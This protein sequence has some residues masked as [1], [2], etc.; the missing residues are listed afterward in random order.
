M[1]HIGSLNWFCLE[2]SFA[3]PFLLTVQ[4]EEKLEGGV[5]KKNIVR[6]VFS[7]F[8]T[9]IFL[10]VCIYYQGMPVFVNLLMKGVAFNLMLSVV[11][12]KI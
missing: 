2:T 7:R 11:L 8:C 6:R 1:W 10:E 4:V 3:D 5:Q 12:S 9:P